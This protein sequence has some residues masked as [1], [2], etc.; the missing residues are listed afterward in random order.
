MVI[1]LA[2]IFHCNSRRSFSLFSQYLATVFRKLWANQWCSK[3]YGA[4][5]ANCKA[6]QPIQWEMDFIHSFFQF[7]S[8]VKIH[9]NLLNFRLG[10]YVTVF[11]A[12]VG[13]DHNDSYCDLR[14]R[15]PSFARGDWRELFV[16]ITA[17]FKFG[18]CFSHSIPL[19][20]RFNIGDCARTC[21]GWSALP[22]HQWTV[23]IPGP[24]GP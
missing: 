24:L 2:S 10:F 5:M 21:R 20:R 22:Q 18:I 6:I 11:A 17:V 4:I 9:N 7:E 16:H 23:G 14:F 19:S 13:A 15:A 3:N 12:K 1:I 8:A